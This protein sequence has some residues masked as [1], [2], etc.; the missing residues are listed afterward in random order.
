MLHIKLKGMEQRAP[1]KNI[2]CSYTHPRSQGGG[3]KVKTF[4]FFKVVMLH[5]REYKYDKFAV[6]DFG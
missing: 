1:C 2:F 5:R 6:L 4:Y 3:Q